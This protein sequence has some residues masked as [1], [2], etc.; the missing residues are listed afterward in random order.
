VNISVEAATQQAVG[1]RKKWLGRLTYQS[2][3]RGSL[4]AFLTAVLALFWVLLFASPALAQEKTINYTHT[5]LEN[6]D[7]SNADLVGAVFV[8]AEMRETNFAGA[9]LTNAMLTKGNLLGA[10]LRGANLTGALIDRVTLYKADLT[11]AILVEA[12]LTNSILDEATVTGA[13]F[14]NALIDRYTIAKLCKYADGVNP[15]TGIETRESLGC[16]S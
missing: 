7:F 14:T 4:L 16:R 3:W 8:S 1:T 5:S 6:R 11:N 10:N 2:R 9:N 13:D 15:V 12:T